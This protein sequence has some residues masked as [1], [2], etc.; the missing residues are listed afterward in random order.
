MMPI[1]GFRT[2]LRNVQNANAKP[3]VAAV[4][5]IC[6]TGLAE[7]S[8]HSQRNDLD[9]VVEIGRNEIP[10]GWIPEMCLIKY[11]PLEPNGYPSL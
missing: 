7:G 2:A 1:R 4:T 8:Q 11:L 5:Y 10:G 9:W 3:T 6:A